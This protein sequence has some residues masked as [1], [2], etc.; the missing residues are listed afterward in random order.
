M[1]D[2]LY[3]TALEFE[4]LTHIGYRI[5]LGR[6]NKTFELQLRFPKKS[7]FHLTGLQHLSDINFSS[8]NKERIY[9]EILR[10]KITF[11]DIAKSVFFEEFFINERLF[12]LKQLENMLDACKLIFLINHQEYIQHT[13]I[14]ADYLCE[15]VMTDSPENILYFFLVEDI[16]SQLD[17]AYVGCSFFQKHDK[18]YRQGTSQT[19]LLLTEKIINVNT[20]EEI[21][22][23]IYRNPVYKENFTSW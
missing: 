19:K 22:T 6:K 8:K 10:Q 17:N 20:S 9:R 21:T 4:K 16:K 5:L 12:Y 1:T 7:F 2:L 15:Y 3:E 18:D 13:K 11:T 14:Y 23:E